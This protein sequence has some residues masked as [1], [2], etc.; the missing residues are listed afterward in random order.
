MT[1]ELNAFVQA[2]KI[3]SEQSKK[4]DPVFEQFIGNKELDS[5]KDL[6]ERIERANKIVQYLIY[7]LEDLVKDMHPG[8][9]LW[10]SQEYRLDIA[11]PYRPDLETSYDEDGIILHFKDTKYGDLMLKFPGE[12]DSWTEHTYTEEPFLVEVAEKVVKYYRRIV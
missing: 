3:V 1:K 11:L 9:S 8:F 10:N 12:Y 2:N 6:R 5:V 4:L 7:L